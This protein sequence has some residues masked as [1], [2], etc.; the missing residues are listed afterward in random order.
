[1]PPD[2]MFPYELRDVHHLN[3]ELLR[4]VSAAAPGE[5]LGDSHDK[6]MAVVPIG[7]ERCALRGEST[8]EGVAEYLKRVLVGTG[9]YAVAPSSKGVIHR[10]T[11]GE[12][13]GRIPGFYLYT[14]QDFE[15]PR[16]LATADGAPLG[17]KQVAFRLLD[18]VALLHSLGHQRLH[19]IPTQ[20]DLGWH[21]QVVLA[22]DVIY[23]DDFYPEWRYDATVLAWTSASSPRVGDL[24]VGPD[25]T[26]DEIA[27]EILKR[28]TDR[29]RGIDWAYA[30]W[31]AELVAEAYRVDQLPA[32][33]AWH[34]GSFCWALGYDTGMPFPPPPVSHDRLGY[35]DVFPQPKIDESLPIPIP[36]WSATDITKRA[37]FGHTFYAFFERDDGLFVGLYVTTS[38]AM[39]RRE[40]LIW[41]PVS[42][43]S[44]GE[45]NHT[46]VIEVS[47]RFVKAHDDLEARNARPDWSLADRMRVFDAEPPQNPQA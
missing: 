41:T 12:G 30:G 10:V 34:A 23:H 21:F 38:E 19:V 17:W 9:P 26:V 45:T 44:Y 18:A 31:Y 5:T 11:V 14:H 2:A 46:K 42:R 20:G 8:R 40:H 16:V 32:S 24:T 13:A 43:D 36:T 22:E 4:W 3:Q 35:T 27:R 33:D 37:D 47:Y 15:Q 29:G 1:M 25:T 39:Y 6:Y 28:T 7:G